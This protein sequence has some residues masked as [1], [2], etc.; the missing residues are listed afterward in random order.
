MRS[1]APLIATILLLAACR[2][3][4]EPVANRYDRQKAEIENTAHTLESQV[5]NEV[6]AA[7]ARL[8]NEVDVL[9]R[10]QAQPP[11]EANATGNVTR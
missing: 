10:N 4:E 3:E 11:A 6:G 8:Q 2:Q 7:E 5:E 9:I 1:P